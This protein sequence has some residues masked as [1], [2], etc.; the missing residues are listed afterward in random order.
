MTTP[1]DTNISLQAPMT[2]PN[3]LLVI[4]IPLDKVKLPMLSSIKYNGIRALVI[5]KVFY[6]RAGNGIALPVGMR[7]KLMPLLEWADKNMLVLD[8]ELNSNSYNTVGETMSIIAG[9]IPLPEDFRFKVFYII[10]ERIWRN[11]Y[12]ATMDS[13]VSH[14]NFMP[15][16]PRSEAVR[17]VPIS[18]KEEFLSLIESGQFSGI[19]GHML[20]NPKGHYKHGRVTEREAT[21]LKYK[22]YGDD[23]DA[24]IIDITYRKEKRDDVPVKR[25]VFDKAKTVHTQDSFELTDIGGCLVCKME[26]GETIKTP[27]PM[28][29]PL[30]MRQRAASLFGTGQPGDLKGTW[31]SFRRL[32]CEN[33]GKPISIKKVEFRDAK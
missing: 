17:Q 15:V 28:D 11:E 2:A 7:E 8:G 29:Y 1:H 6:S 16:T 25:S 13:L 23:E 19:E 18:T 4:D 26:N 31:I 32:A 21:L 30:S 5:N 24:Q 3:K 10:P 33:R 12:L 9:T 20:L 22:Y 27:F 14:N